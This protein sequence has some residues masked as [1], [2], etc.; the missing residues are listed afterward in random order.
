VEVVDGTRCRTG[1]PVDA[2]AR[3]AAVPVD[4][5]TRGGRVRIA[6]PA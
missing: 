4:A 1:P 5:A 6:L 3:A 2:S